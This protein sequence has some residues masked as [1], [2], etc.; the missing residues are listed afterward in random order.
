MDSKIF[1]FWQIQ[2]FFFKKILSF[3]NNKTLLPVLSFYN[4]KT[5]LLVLTKSY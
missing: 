5:F 4:N 3:T 1:D 2:I